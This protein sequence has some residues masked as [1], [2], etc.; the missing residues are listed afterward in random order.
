VAAPLL[1][2]QLALSDWGIRSP[3]NFGTYMPHYMSPEQGR[4]WLLELAAGL[5]VLAA[6]GL[7]WRRR[8]A[9]RRAG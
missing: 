8:E 1:A 3:R 7:L 5:A 6:L 9:R 4:R 2:I